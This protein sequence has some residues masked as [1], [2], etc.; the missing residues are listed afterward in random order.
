MKP[1]PSISIDERGILLHLTNAEGEGI[2]VPIDPEG[3]A[4]LAEHAGKALL[5]LKTDKGRELVK[6]ALRTLWKGLTGDSQP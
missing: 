1:K 6:D 2:A 3:L 4:L 5:T